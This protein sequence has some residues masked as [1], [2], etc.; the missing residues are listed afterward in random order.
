MIRCLSLWLIVAGFFS[1]PGHVW[2]IDEFSDLKTI[3]KLPMAF[4]EIDQEFQRSRAEAC[5]LIPAGESLEISSYT[6]VLTERD[7][8]EGRNRQLIPSSR[9]DL[10]SVG[11]EFERRDQ[12]ALPALSRGTIVDYLNEH[13]V[14]IQGRIRR[15]LLDRKPYYHHRPLA[16][17]ARYRGTKLTQKFEP[18]VAQSI[19]EFHSLG[20]FVPG[21]TRLKRPENYRTIVLLFRTEM[22]VP[23]GSRSRESFE[24][25]FIRGREEGS[26]EGLQL[27]PHIFITSQGR[28]QLEYLRLSPRPLSPLRCGVLGRIAVTEFDSAGIYPTQSATRSYRLD[29]RSTWFLDESIAAYCQQQAWRGGFAENVTG[30]LDAII[31]GHLTAQP[32]K[33]AAP[34]DSGGGL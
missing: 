20:L 12:E 19:R 25:A 1:Q 6:S 5:E 8:T 7:R 30:V 29:S 3:S 26:G 13:Y 11:L 14:S 27:Q 9:R 4:R 24:F 34:A 22:L 31:D 23:G 10:F 32:Q 16:L 17:T 18:I 15:D 2:A 28:T 33:S 21:D